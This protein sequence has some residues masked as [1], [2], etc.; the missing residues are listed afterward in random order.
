MFSFKLKTI[1]EY[2]ADLRQ[3]RPELISTLIHVSVRNL[4]V[5]IMASNFEKNYV[6]FESNCLIF[7]ADKPQKLTL[8]AHTSTY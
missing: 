2:K 6:L 5:E 3:V 8:P 7:I 4:P 1:N